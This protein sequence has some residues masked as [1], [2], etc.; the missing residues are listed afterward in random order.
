MSSD[1][2]NTVLADLR[3]GGVLW[4][5]L[6]RPER[7]NAVSK[8]LYD[9][10]CW[11]L[12]QA[13]QNPDVRVVVLTGA[14]RAFCVGADMKAHA[15]GTRT[16]FEKR[17]YLRGE[18]E[19]CRRLFELRKPVVAAVNGY[20]LGAGAELAL[21]ADFM[22]MQSTAIWG[23]PETSIGAF[24]GG[25]VS[26]LLPARV[27]LTKAKELVMLG[28]R[29]NGVQALSIGLAQRCFEAA[30]SQ[31]FQQQVQAFALQLASKAPISMMLAKQQLNRAGQQNFEDALTA[32]LE[33]MMFCTTT[34]DWQEGV[35]AFAAK[36][37]PVF[38]GL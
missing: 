21:A 6:N 30:D 2:A 7:L 36:R 11:L 32:E 26:W 28:E 16:A 31:D 20:A 37:T 22:L 34:R 12:D 4:I 24:I 8:P 5:T 23:L 35:D 25:G 9:R 18:Q 33:G 19:V 38:T 1:A 17:E 14:G 3:E 15:E 13:E 29:I 10:L 27:G